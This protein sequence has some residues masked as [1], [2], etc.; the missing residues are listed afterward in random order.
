M[1][2]DTKRPD[3]DREAAIREWQQDAAAWMEQGGGLSAA[4]GLLGQ[5]VR[6]LEWPVLEPARTAE[7]RRLAEDTNRQDARAE[8]RAL[9][10]LR[11]RC[12]V[13][14][15]VRNWAHAVVGAQRH[16]HPE[17]IEAARFILKLHEASNEPAGQPEAQADDDE[18]LRAM[19]S[20]HDCG[21]YDP[22][23]TAEIQDALA[24]LVRRELAR[25]TGNQGER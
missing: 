23:T 22:S 21:H 5:A 3:T 7:M 17:D 8:L 24:E 25:S 13:P 9:Q 14:D 4:C 6:F 12:A 15:S 20:I 1:T 11:K 10:E 19:L 2:D 18:P 16:H